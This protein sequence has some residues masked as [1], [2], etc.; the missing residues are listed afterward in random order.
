M[1]PWWDS[2]SNY[3][4]PYDYEKKTAEKIK[5]AKRS[6]A[7][8]A[9][10]GDFDVQSQ[11]LLVDNKRVSEGHTYRLDYRD[12]KK[13]EDK[14]KLDQIPSMLINFNKHGG[15]LAVIREK[16]FVA[17]INLLTELEE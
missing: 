14:A 4:D 1:S 9:L 10:F 17:L 7:S 15:S 6:I 11:N 16:D 12:F 8:G 13:V 3:R 2:E 5:G